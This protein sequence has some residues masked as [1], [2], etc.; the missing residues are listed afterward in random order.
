MV[1]GRKPA[2]FT[3]SG[4]EPVLKPEICRRP[5]RIASIWA[6]LDWT[7]KKITS[8]PVFSFR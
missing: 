7:G 3:A 6:A 4:F 5:E 8:L 1:K 2:Q